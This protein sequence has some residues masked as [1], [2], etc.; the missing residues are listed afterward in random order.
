MN[1]PRVDGRRLQGSEYV[2][3]DGSADPGLVRA[4]HGH[5][6]GTTHYPVAL[7]ALAPARVL[8][9]VVAVLGEV[10]YDD[11]GLARDK[12]SDMAAV[13]L[14]GADGRRAL[15]AFTSTESLAAWDPQARPVPVAA[16]LAAATAVQEG[17]AALVVDVAGPAT[18][19]LEGEDLHRVAAGWRPV[20]LSDG[21]WG[22]L[23]QDPAAGD[24]VDDDSAER[25]QTR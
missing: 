12:S 1:E 20:R 6:A 18:F 24:G 3:D 17:A 15:L 4:L 5:A 23:G 10:E 19:V 11:A 13:L 21:G 25:E 16:H 2:G 7:A 22:W 14:T 8:V 9:P